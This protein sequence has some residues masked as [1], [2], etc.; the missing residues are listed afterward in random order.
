[1][2]ISGNLALIGAHLDRDGDQFVGAA[3]LFDVNTGEQL[4][5]FRSGDGPELT[6]GFGFSAAL[7][8]RTAVIGSPFADS[9]A[10]FATGAAYVFDVSDP[11]RP[12]R[13]LKLTSADEEA[14]DWFGM[15]VALQGTTILVGASQELTAAGKAFVFHGRSAP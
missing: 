7:S 9:A 14:A 12:V 11:R 1:M 13:I 8:G 5:K 15:P 6:S 4:A 3:Y 2:A 10:G